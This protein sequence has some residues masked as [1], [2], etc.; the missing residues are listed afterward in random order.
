MTNF[1]TVPNDWDN[2][3]IVHVN[4]HQWWNKTTDVK[5]YLVDEDTFFA[6]RNR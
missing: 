4:G 5:F 2:D 3:V 6:K 1:M